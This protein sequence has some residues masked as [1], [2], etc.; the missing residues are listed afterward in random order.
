MTLDL[1]EKLNRRLISSVGKLDIIRR[2]AQ[3]ESEAMND[4]LRRLILTDYIKK[5]E[6]SSIASSQEFSSVNVVSIFETLR[7]AQL[8]VNI[9]VLLGSLVILP[10]SIDLAEIKHQ[11]ENIPPSIALLIFPV[12]MSVLSIS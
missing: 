10:Q 2:I 5:E 6:L 1:N 4:W 11:K 3:S 7:R 8:R 12:R 9:G